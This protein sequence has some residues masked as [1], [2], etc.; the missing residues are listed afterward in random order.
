MVDLVVTDGDLVGR[1][2][3][4]DESDLDV[5]LAE[6]DQLSATT[7]PR[8]T[9]V[10]RVLTRVADAFDRRDPDRYLALFAKDC[11]YEDRRKGLRDAGSIRPDYAHTVTF[12]AAAGWQAEFETIAVRGEHLMLG[13]AT[14]RDQSEPGSPIAVEALNVGRVNSDE[15]ISWFAVFDP[16]DIDAA[17]DELTAQWT[18]SGEV[19]HPEV[20]EAARQ[21]FE[22]ANR[23]DWDALAARESGATF[24]NHR[25]LG[26][27]STIDDHWSSIRTMAALIPDMHMEVVD[28]PR[29][30]AIGL[31]AHVAV[32]G[33][34]GEDTAIELPVVILL[35]FDGT[36]VTRMENF[37]LS[38]RD[39]ALAR[40][41]ELNQTAT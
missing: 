37:D 6:F 41:D 36:R 18:A 15:L 34:T 11:R 9:T 28:I 24:V 32:R 5:A 10:A 7:P 40:F 29:H 30:S 4:F 22:V 25:Q 14:F 31:V 17:F 13:R 21:L 33:T 2:E 27:G 26:T 20:I 39:E 3:S 8:N 16:D 23:H 1:C 12:G 38:Q 19:A 35:A